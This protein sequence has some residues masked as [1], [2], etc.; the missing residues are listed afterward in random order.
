M[1][2]PQKDGS[3][4]HVPYVVETTSEKEPVYKWLCINS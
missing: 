4:W 1:I 3:F 2:T